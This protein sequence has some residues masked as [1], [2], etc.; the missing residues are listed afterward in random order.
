M[1]GEPIV[2]RGLKALYEAAHA[3][4][5]LTAAYPS[6][7][8]NMLPEGRRYRAKDGW[9]EIKA[10]PETDAAYEI[11]QSNAAVN[12]DREV[13]YM[14]TVYICS[15]SDRTGGG[16]SIEFKFERVRAQG[17][18][19]L[20]GEAVKLIEPV[21]GGIPPQLEYDTLKTR[22]VNLRSSMSKSRA[23]GK[24]VYSTAFPTV[25]EGYWR[26]PKQNWETRIYVDI[27]AQY[28]PMT[29]FKGF[30]RRD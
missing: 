13:D 8:N 25:Q 1:D 22:L 30:T 5:G 3:A 24:Q 7:R 17:L 18:M 20:Y 12:D 15:K 6:V 27:A 19:N 28:E 4:W 14:A 21:L 26:A 9:V 2:A 11:A 10:D 23:G 16:D 29:V